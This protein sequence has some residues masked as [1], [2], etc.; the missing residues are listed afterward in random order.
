MP[1]HYSLLAEEELESL[2]TLTIIVY[3]LQGVSFFVGGIS[4]IAAV[5][6]N[7]IKLKDVQGTWLESHFRW[8]IRTFWYFLLWTVIGITTV[9]LMVG[10]FILFA[11]SIWFIYRVIKGGLRLSENKEMYV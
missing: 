11:N 3:V 9:F 2:K 5:I 6:I 4:L 10:F 8:Q 1:K 7:Y